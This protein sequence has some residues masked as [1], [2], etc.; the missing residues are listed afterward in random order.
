MKSLLLLLS[1]LL[2]PSLLPSPVVPDDSE[3]EERMHAIEDHIRKLRRSLRDE[4]GTAAS[5]EL[6]AELQA[7]TLACKLLTPHTV[8]N[9]PE[10]E[11]AAFLRDYRK[12][13]AELLR[14][15]IALEIALLEGD[16][17]AATTAFRAIRA[18]EDPGH[19][20]F[21]GEEH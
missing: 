21:A 13:M 11:R 15:E 20:R 6:V 12:T 16:T 14:E 7:D 8:E 19:E 9:V 10:A 18:M 17:E 3:L 4:E 2:L 5:L 1:L